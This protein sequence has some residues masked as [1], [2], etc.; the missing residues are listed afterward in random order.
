MV[1]H[2]LSESESWV[3]EHPDLLVTERAFLHLLQ[4]E[5][6]KAMRLYK[7]IEKDDLTAVDY[8]RLGNVYLMISDFDQ[9][10]RYYDKA[11]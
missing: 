11:I 4:N 6:A 5:G 2:Y 10:L 9:A 8:N 3:Y 7:Q 1:Q